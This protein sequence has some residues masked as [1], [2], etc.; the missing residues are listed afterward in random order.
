MIMI[1]KKL[2][3]ISLF[4]FL[5]LSSWHCG[6]ESS[7]V[8]APAN[9]AVLHG[10]I[11]DAGDMKLFLDEWHF[12]NTTNVLGYTDIKSD[13]SFELPL[14][15]E[16]Q[17]GIY[18][19]RIGAKKAFL[20][21]DGTEK[22]VAVNG[23]L[24]E[25]DKFGFEVKGSNS[26][27]QLKTQLQKAIADPSDVEAIRTAAENAANPVIGGYLAMV[28]YRENEALLNSYKEVNAKLQR[29]DKD[30]KYAK[31]FNNFIAG[32]EQRIAVRKATASLAVG[33]VA[34]DIDLPS[35]DGKNYKLSDLKGKVVLL[36]FWASW[37]GPCRKSNPHVVE[38]YKKYKNKGFTVFSVSLDGIHP[39]MLPN[40]GND[41]AKI[42][43]QMEAAKTKWVAAIKRDQ[44]L[45][46]T[47]VSDLKHWNSP[48]AK[49]YNVKGI[50][51]TYLIDRDG[52]IAL[53]GINP[54]SPTF[55]LETEIKKLL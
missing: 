46:E 9:G 16:L 27:N 35:P 15:D 20:A 21:F 43:A 1:M 44:L 32:I 12:D 37:C 51:N 50:P 36:D 11:A 48:V 54:L 13:G 40:L 5:A 22:K 47:H 55:D 38:T 2:S 28:F 17:M 34:P 41:Q 24:V 19:M 45:W 7:S 53:A 10:K 25:F 14:E 49:M 39:R 4:M 31:D 26:A 52:K 33:Q 18:R 30:S 6:G 29:A 42:N 3:I 23:K 8:Q